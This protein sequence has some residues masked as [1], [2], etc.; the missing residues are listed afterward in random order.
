MSTISRNNP[1]YSDLDMDFIPHPNSRDV[2]KK[3]GLD[4]LKRSVRN[5]I[6]TN[7]YDRKF[8]SYIGSHCQAMLFEPVTALTSH[9][10]RDA[11]WEVISNY[12]PRIELVDVIVNVSDERNGY[13]ATVVG[14]EVN[15]S[16]PLE[17][18][19]FLERIR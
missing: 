11:I 19:F 9:A 13:T 16:Q 14:I 10:I 12:E 4:A 1:P 3:T 15:R 18:S 8:Q 2:L 6:M 5:L 7:F 17:I